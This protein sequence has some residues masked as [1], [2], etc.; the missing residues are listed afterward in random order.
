MKKWKKKSGIPCTGCL[1]LLHGSIGTC[2]KKN[3]NSDYVSTDR[4]WSKCVPMNL[5]QTPL[6]FN[7][8][9]THNFGSLLA[10]LLASDAYFQLK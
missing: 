10:S 2:E 5:K 3:E 8:K 7:I 4:L 1:K 6:T 9:L